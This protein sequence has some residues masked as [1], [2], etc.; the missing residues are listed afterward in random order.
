MGESPPG[1]LGET[2]ALAAFGQAPAG[3]S[4]CSQSEHSED[5]LVQEFIRRGC[6]KTMRVQ[7]PHPQSSP[8]RRGLSGGRVTGTQRQ[9]S[10]LTALGL[11]FSGRRQAACLVPTE[12]EVGMSTLTTHRP[13]PPTLSPAGQ[14]QPE[15]EGKGAI[16]IVRACQRAG[17]KGGEGVCR[18]TMKTRGGGHFVEQVED[19][20]LCCLCVLG[21]WPPVCLLTLRVGNGWPF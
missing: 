9:E 16:F 7:S 20:E 11:L 13:S 4:W 2:T 12:R 1:Y 14:S 3:S 6:R 15:A 5:V 8:G 19:L 18:G 17:A 21:P 10:F